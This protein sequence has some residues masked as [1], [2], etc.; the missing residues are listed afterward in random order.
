M[1]VLKVKKGKKAT[2]VCKGGRNAGKAQ[3]TVVADRIRFR[4]EPLPQNAVVTSSVPATFTPQ[5]CSI[6]VPMQTC[7]RPLPNLA[8]S[9]VVQPRPAY[10]SEVN[11]G[12]H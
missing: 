4:A 8:Y 10:P 3:S 9:N 5:Q 7:Q 1:L 6:E 12:R 2:G 11:R